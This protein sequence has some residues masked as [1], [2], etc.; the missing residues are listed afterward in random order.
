MRREVLL[1]LALG[2]LVSLLITSTGFSSSELARRG[3]LTNPFASFL[4]ACPA[5][6]VVAVGRASAYGR[7]VFWVGISFIVNFSLINTL[8]LLVVIR[9][10]GCNLFFLL[11]SNYGD[12]RK[13]CPF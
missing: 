4:P 5:A 13:D 11:F 7:R 6:D 9:K 3:A 12:L 8:S 1:A 10:K 2:Q